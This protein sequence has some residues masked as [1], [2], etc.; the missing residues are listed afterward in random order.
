MQ[1]AFHMVCSEPGFRERL[2][3]TLE[4]IGDIETLGC[5]REI[6]AKGLVWGGKYR[7]MNGKRSC[8]ESGVMEVDLRKGA[9]RE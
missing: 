6:V 8:G 9:E 1:R 2:K 7:V 5:T 3:A 4:R